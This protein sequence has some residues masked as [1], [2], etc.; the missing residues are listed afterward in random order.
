MKYPA[1]MGAFVVVVVGYLVPAF[2]LF[3]LFWT[4]DLGAWTPGDRL[5]CLVW[6]FFCFA[7][8]F[9]IEKDFKNIERRKRL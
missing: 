7:L 5:I 4:S 6:F 3:D 1:C 2:V 9:A 8:G